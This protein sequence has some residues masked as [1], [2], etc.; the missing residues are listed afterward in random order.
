MNTQETSQ[1]N[2]FRRH[3]LTTTAIIGIIAAVLVVGGTLFF[4][5]DPFN[6][7]VRGNYKSLTEWTPENIAKNPVAYLDFVELK[8]K[9]AQQQLKADRI[10][11]E[12]KRGQLKAMQEEASNKARVGEQTLKELKDAY[13]N[14]GEG[15][16]TQISFRGQQ[17]D[18]A[19]V[20]N[21]VVNIYK[22]TE[23]QKNILKK[24]EAGLKKLD[25][26]VEK[27]NKAEGE[28]VAQ[29]AEV[30]ANRELLKVQKLTDDLKDRLVEMRGAVQGVVATA[31]EDADSLSLDTLASESQTTVDTK[32]FDKIMGDIK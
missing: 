23:T 2:R 22:Q 12:Q 15:Q 29:L 26:Q 6:M 5:S 31:S 11:V 3:G 19:W 13:E 8:T 25:A 32:E 30:K 1:E 16:T 28:A 27:I 7:W 18:A 17:K 20:K 14:A 9:E 4:I 21:Q 10:S 24:V